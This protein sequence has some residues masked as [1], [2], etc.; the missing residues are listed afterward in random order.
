[1]K[2]K[3]IHRTATFAWS[4]T[5]NVPLLATGGVAGALDESF[6][7]DSHL[8]IW[9]P[10]FFDKSEFDLGH[11][12]HPGPKGS[13]TTSSRFNRLAWGYVHPARPQGVIAAGME[14]GEL[15]LWDPEKI[16]VSAEPSEA[17]IYSN[18]THTG[19]VRGLDFN[20]LQNNLLATGAVNGEVYIW[21]LKDPSKPYSPG[22][23]SS[24]L[25]EITSLAWNG[26]VAHILATSSS[27]GYTVV[28]DLRGKRE[29]VAL[30]YAGGAGT[31]GQVSAVGGALGAKRGMSDVCWH[32]D[33]ATRLVTASEDDTSP[34]IMVWDLRNARAPE[35]L[36]EGHDKGVLSLSWCRQDSDLLLSCGKDNR[37]LCWN[38]NT[39]EII[40]ELPAGDNWAF[41]VDWCPKNPDLLATAYF[42]G[43]IGVHSLQ[44]TNADSPDAR[45]A[46]AAPQ[47]DGSDVFDV[48]GYS[49][50]KSQSKLSLK[51][52]PKWLRRPASC[53]FGYGG[54]LVTVSN[55]A[56]P[57]GKNQSSSVHLHQVVTE[58]T[59][60][61]RAKSLLDA[62]SSED[63]IAL[64]QQKSEGAQ[65]DAETWKA[66]LSL[67]RANSRDELVTM[68]GFSKAEITT[69][70]AEA[71]K[72]LQESRAADAD[73]EADDV[74]TSSGNA[75][76]VSFAEPE[77]TPEVE[78]EP[79]IELEIDEAPTTPSEQ[80]DATKA[81][82]E[83]TATELSLFG[84]EVANEQDANADF[85]SSMGGL[86]N[87]IP[88][89]VR[90]PH[91]SLT[92]DSSAAATIGSGPPS[93]VS[94][95][96]KQTTFKF[97]PSDESELDRLLTKSLV[98]GDF[99]SAV[100]LCLAVDRYA[101]AIL[102][103]AKG[104]PD[105][106]QRTQK[107]YFERRTTTLPYLRLFQSIVTNDL[108]DIVQN[109]DLREWQ[110]I[111]VVIC[112][113]AKPDEFAS[114]A[115]QLGQRLEYQ[116]TVVLASDP[117]DV[118]AAHELRKRATLAYLAAR[119]LEKVVNIW[120][121][122]MREEEARIGEGEGN[123][124]RYTTHALA[125]QGFVEKVTVF[126]HATSYTDDDLAQTPAPEAVA[127]AKTYKL[128]A[129]YDRYY[130]YAD[131]LASQGLVREAVKYLDLT[132]ADYT[133]SAGQEESFSVARSRLLTAAGKSSQ[134]VASTS[135]QAPSNFYQAA[136]A[137]ATTPY[138]S[139]TTTS[140]AQSFTTAPTQSFQTPAKPSKYPPAP[141]FTQ[142]HPYGRPGEPSYPPANAAQSAPSPYAPAGGSSSYQPVS[143]YQP[144]AQNTGYQPPSNGPGPRSV[145][146]PGGTVP[147]PLGPPPA[148]SHAPAP[149]PP[150]PKRDA[151]G[152][153]DA[154]VLAERR[155]SPA[156]TASGGKSTPAPITSP[157]PNMPTAP[158]SPA[159]FGPPN[160]G[161]APPPRGG[162]PGAPPPRP[163][164]TV[165][166][167][168][169]RPGMRSTPPP[170]PPPH[171]GPARPPSAGPPRGTFPPGVNAPV[172][173]LSPLGQG[174]RPPPP[175]GAAPM[176]RNAGGPPPP[177]QQH[178]SSPPPPPG[179]QPS[180][181]RPPPPPGQGFAPGTV[182]GQ[183]GFTPPTG[184]SPPP[185]PPGSYGPPPGARPGFPPAGG[186]PP[187]PTGGFAPPPPRGP[188]GAGGPP[189]PPGGPGGPPPPRAAPPPKAPAAP[190]YPPGDRSHIPDSSQAMYN[191]LFEELNRFKAGTP[192][193]Q[194]RMAD[195]V[196]RRV[197]ALFDALNCETV[198]PPVLEGLNA[199]SKAIQAR[200]RP[201]ATT[202][203]VD[204]LT[205][206]SATEDI[207]LWMSGLKQLLL[208][209]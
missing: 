71:I 58:P 73:A 1:M 139:F 60:A 80:S 23:R 158:G 118:D 199:L 104:G 146:P 102:L 18:N 6:S 182:P 107:T 12:G 13:V 75:T 207:G 64:A 22:A 105:L 43:T 33:N 40:G 131:L 3:E 84:D 25:D 189:P 136:P 7:N 181:F 74:D 125:L 122:E 185:P 205:R 132:P 113:F 50:H 154:P 52:P 89:H 124:S 90:I 17:L 156:T 94:E 133:S 206:G 29:V 123:N 30:T 59:I 173:A 91:Y 126:R 16:V 11:D 38:P 143:Q 180:Q 150:P 152:W 119:K 192:P 51:Q 178:F 114:L 27:S 155:S 65:T 194:K 111:F 26:Q 151:G 137:A 39:S 103:A 162:T 138:N 175:R 10:N 95:A 193:Q 112:T 5:Q 202:I 144:P 55:I 37:A 8:E 2:L 14:N 140:T 169:P 128:A 117:D 62:S 177:P 127:Q 198:S 149:P 153:N 32:P 83:S 21:D 106:L 56:G 85:F 87:A 121:A 148:A 171:G 170:P 101:D 200:D 179:Q 28:W 208:R 86:R 183:P 49:S 209:L 66:L 77:P 159:G 88:D 168:P 57:S 54:K 187:P 47:T 109:A 9:S 79:E 72:K 147:P 166:P 108:E 76:R 116:S 35:K 186:P 115:E 100:A 81:A 145:Y 142:P 36:L 20:N 96:V 141:S 172:R 31:V 99:E 195:D 78:R 188:P 46:A 129:L 184:R 161:I 203:H 174:Q 120:I 67:F 68:L 61:E 201:A 160:G 82:T 97:Y 53:S 204:L 34:V 164:S 45:A 44:S 98:L 41:Q 110:E 24:K 42:D 93:V 63:L 176:L 69:H 15:G 163:G 48:P 92:G 4:P 70:V 191:I 167:P 130:E 196:E 135:K 134:P 190:K 165:A 197:N 157:F 19:P